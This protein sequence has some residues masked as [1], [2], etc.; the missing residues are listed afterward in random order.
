MLQAV[1]LFLLAALTIGV[2]FHIFS[3]DDSRPKQ[4]EVPST[5]DA[6]S[7]ANHAPDVSEALS[8][9]I[10]VGEIK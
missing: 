9:G 2:W 6:A 1:A 7:V 5:H 3:R 10:F 4:R 8:N